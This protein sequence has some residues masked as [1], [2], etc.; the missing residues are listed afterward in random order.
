[1]MTREV[2]N[3]FRGIVTLSDGTPLEGASITIAG[4]GVAVASTD[5]KGLFFLEGSGDSMLIGVSYT[6]F[7]RKEIMITSGVSSKI[8]M[9]PLITE[10]SAVAVRSNGYQKI[11][12]ER[13]TGSFV[14]IDNQLLNRRIGPTILERLENIA[15]GLMF[16]NKN[17]PPYSTEAYI[18]VRGRSTILANAQPLIVVDNFPYTGNINLLNPNDVENITILKDAAAASIWGA[19]SGNGVIVIT[20]RKGKLNQAL[21]VE[22]NVNL[23]MGAKPDL[24]YSRNFLPSSEYIPVEQYLFDKGYYDDDLLND[25]SYPLISP[26]VELLDKKRSG[27]M[28]AAVVDAEINRLKGVD[29]RKQFEKYLYRHSLNQQYAINMS[30]GGEHSSYLFSVGYDRNLHN[31]VGDAND[32]FTLNNHSIFNFWGK[33]E[34]STGVSL[35]MQENEI[36]IIHSI[37]PRG[38]KLA[39]SYLELADEKGNALAIPRDYRYSFVSNPP[40]EGLLDWTYRPLDEIRFADN[41]ERR[42]HIR[43]NPGL[44]IPIT[45]G[46]NMELRYQFEKQ[47]SR[48]KNYQSEKTYET[49]NVINLFTQVVDGVL[50]RPLPI[51]GIMAESDGELTSNNYRVQ[52]NYNRKFAGRHSLAAIG[53]FEQRG[54]VTEDETNIYAGY[55]KENSTY[56]TNLDHSTYFDAYRYLGPG[57]YLPGGGTLKQFNNEFISYYGNMTYILDDK[58]KISGSMRFDQSNIWGINANQKGV[59]LWSAGLLW[60]I[61]REKFYKSRIVPT[62]Q[63]RATYGVNGNLDPTV[64]GRLV[65]VTNPIRNVAGLPSSAIANYPNADLTWEKSAML[66]IGADFEIGN[67]ILRGSIEY[68]RKN[69]KGLIGL[70]VPALQVGTD[71]IRTN[72]ATMKG[73]G[74]DFSLSSINVNRKISWT[75]DFIF[76]Y[77]WDEIVKYNFRSPLT[78]AITS[79]DGST[80]ALV[81]IIGK[82]LYGIY[83]Y[84]WGGLDPQNG[85]PI[86]FMGGQPSKEYDKLAGVGGSADIRYHGAARPTMFGAFRNTVS[87]KGL[88]LSVNFGFKLRY[89]FRRSGLSYESLFAKWHGHA[90]YLSRWQKKGDEQW[91]HVPSMIYPLDGNRDYFYQY[92]E[93]LVEK[94]GH[95]R[96][97]DIR[98]SYNLRPAFLSGSQGKYLQLYLYANNIGIVWRANKLKIDPDYVAGGPVPPSLAIGC[99]IVL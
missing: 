74:I 48:V 59:P 68:Y 11:P 37:I 9:Q 63:L 42:Y 19:F 32:R 58:Y 17:I 38:G 12:Q 39:Y 91:T 80:E 2:K 77:N 96:L 53:G 78:T 10:L 84:E 57:G 35:V 8:T 83:S 72:S 75:S 22:A 41:I 95:I 15:S 5:E 90:D 99:K 94:A 65:I 21:K 13:A 43:L 26:V 49:R 28:P 54:I 24:Y 4:T 23:T 44:K 16:P 47:W 71:M 70:V 76:S 40:D 3:L 67:N 27:I 73:G 98:F 87:Y 81:P 79:A 1:M 93:V 14:Q 97:Q 34:L 50:T 69:G 7:Q 51:G 33:A 36:G 66:N 6:G 92:S 88:S 46:L 82:P 85:D 89:Y 31:T 25:Y 64:S 55:N 30:A 18:S 60:D 20:T 29:R 86:G 61:S 62:L 45:N 52:L 56:A